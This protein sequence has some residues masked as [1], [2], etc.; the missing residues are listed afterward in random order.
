MILTGAQWDSNARPRLSRSSRLCFRW[1]RRATPARCNDQP[2]QLRI[3]VPAP[4]HWDEIVAYA[5]TP[6]VT[7]ESEKRI[8]ARPALDL[9]KQIRL[10]NRRVN[11]GYLKA[12]GL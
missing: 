3:D 9:W 2:N 11:D 6:G 5:K 7:G 8:A 1:I 4:V 10:E 12:L